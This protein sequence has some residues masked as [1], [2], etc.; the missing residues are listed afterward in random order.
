MNERDMTTEEL[1]NSNKSNE[2]RNKLA[3]GVVN[4]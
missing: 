2:K 3:G 4:E 1:E